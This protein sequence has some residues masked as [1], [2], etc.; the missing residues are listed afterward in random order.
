MEARQKAKNRNSKTI[1]LEAPRKENGEKWLQAET[2][3]RLKRQSLTTEV[4]ALREELQATRR[5]LHVSESQLDQCRSQLK[6]LAL[7]NT[8]LLDDND[9]KARKLA[10]SQ[11]AHI[12]QLSDLAESHAKSL[13]ELKQEHQDVIS[14]KQS[15]FDERLALQKKAL[16]ELAAKS[17]SE[18]SKLKEQLRQMEEANNNVMEKL[19]K[20]LIVKEKSIEEERK[21]READRQNNRVT[22]KGL[23]QKIQEQAKVITAL[24]DKDDLTRRVSKL[25]DTI[26]QKDAVI[27]NKDKEIASLRVEKKGVMEE[28][29]DQRQKTAS[30]TE[31]VKNLKENNQKLKDEL[32]IEHAKLKST[33]DELNKSRQ[34]NGNLTEHVGHLTSKVKAS[35]LEL[36]KLSGE[37]EDMA[38]YVLLVKEDIESVISV[39]DEPNKLINRVINFKRRYI[40]NEENVQM[41][42]ITRHA[43]GHELKNL[44]SE[45]ETLKK[46]LKTCSREKQRLVEEVDKM[47]K[48]KCEM[49][50]Y[51]IQ[52]I[53]K[54]KMEEQMGSKP[55][56]PARLVPISSK[57]KATPS[58]SQFNS[59]ARNVLPTI[60]REN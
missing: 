18:V 55:M 58:R 20:E 52:M 8:Q 25:E 44:K 6:Q 50:S 35:E 2:N 32:R 1:S 19:Q 7:D 24:K 31:M 23:E 51:Y 36:T 12:Q 38:M 42:E 16:K 13:E 56:R 48:A 59:S 40:D 53:N 11:A 57:S 47:Y 30:L 15:D 10:K 9:R 54:K 39:I 29:Q 46:A 26:K 60:G 17:K 37:V 5:K 41:D 33:T 28:L 43:A 22:C 27:K 3:N 45:N 34:A 21:Y 14:F 4:Q 49:E